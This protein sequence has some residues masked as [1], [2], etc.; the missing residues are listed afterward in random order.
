[1]SIISWEWW[2]EGKVLFIDTES[3]FHLE[4]LKTIEERFGLEV[5]SNILYVRAYNSVH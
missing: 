4:K 1:M 5:I 2:G 3:T